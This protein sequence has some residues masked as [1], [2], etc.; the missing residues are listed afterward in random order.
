MDVVRLRILRE[1]ADRGTVAATA[2]ALSMTPSAVSQQLKVLAREAGVPLLEPDGRR[3]RFTDAGRALVVR[4]DEV[5][6]ALDRAADE[7][8]AYA[9]SPRGRVRVASFPS[10]AALLLPAVL[11]AAG[12]IGVELDVSDE[13]VPASAAPAL[14]AD[15][16]VVLTHR[17]ERSAPLSGPRVHVETLMRE[18]ID[19]VLPP[20]HRLA[21]QDRVQVDELVGERWISVRGGFPVDDVLLSVA[22]VTGIR[23]RVVHR[24]NDFRVIEELVAAGHGVALLPRYSVLHPALVRLP[25]AGV[26]AAR[27][28]ELVTRP[29]ASRRPAVGAVL[30]SFRTAAARKL[31][32]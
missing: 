14:L 6:D 9:R 8:T 20:G 32:M 4:A 24:I 11:E 28:Y 10:G 1:L 12:A 26:R 30:D 3:L 21:A 25:L 7:M 17:D 19:V 16:D 31:S 27:I 29:G 13:D 5:L 18:P 2:A 15:Y 22:A 23:A